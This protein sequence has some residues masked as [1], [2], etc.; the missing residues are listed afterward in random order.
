[1]N[2]GEGGVPSWRSRSVSIGRIHSAER[3]VKLGRHPRFVVSNNWV[4]HEVAGFRFLASKCNAVFV[5]QNDP[6]GH[7]RVDVTEP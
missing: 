2:N 1:M 7:W 5:V 6:Q 3:R 4:A